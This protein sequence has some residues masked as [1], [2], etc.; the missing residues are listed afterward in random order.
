MVQACTVQLYTL[1]LIMRAISS[2][3]STPN[4]RDTW[5]KFRDVQSPLPSFVL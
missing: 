2:A 4:E 5:N 3:G 1:L